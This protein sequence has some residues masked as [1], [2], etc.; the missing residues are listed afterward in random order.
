M[1]RIRVLLVDDSVTI[2]RL[3][4]NALAEESDIEVV[5][6]APNGRIALAK[7]D[8][9]NPEVVVLDVEMPEMDGLTTLT[10]LRK[11]RPRLPVIMFSTLTD[12][13][14]TVTL[15]ALARGAS[16]YVAKPSNTGSMQKSVEIIRDQ[17]VPKIRALAGGSSRS[18]APPLPKVVPSL[19]NLNRTVDI[20]VLGTSTGGPNAL[21]EIIPALPAD[22]PVPMVLVQH[23][24]PIFTR[25][26]AERLNATSR[27]RVEEAV[28][29]RVLEPG[30]V[31]IAPGNFHMT[32]VRD[33]TCV[34]VA[35]DQE[36]PENSCRP[37][38]DRLF[39]SVADL[40]GASA[41]GV[42]LTG[43]GQDGLRGCERL[44]ECGAHVLAQDEAT[45]VVWGMP[46]YV[47]RAGLANCTVPLSRVAH[48]I[49]RR[50]QRTRP[51]A[52]FAITTG[53]S[54]P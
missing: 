45:S 26:L 34:R 46:G 2:R 42:V 11:V 4:T 6:A 23:M 36:A 19:T 12:R 14:A 54:R 30:L 51:Q 41:L 50:I 24:P 52:P 29:G 38:V 21:A 35:L 32:L 44:R 20:V 9:V 33:G 28:E 18:L 27:V 7:L 16:D 17:L 15:D 40:Y 39:R 49:S 25:L 43:M 5:G 1:T 8:Q 10:E 47:V 31:L 48:E 3:L 37:A 53:G 22:L 13:G